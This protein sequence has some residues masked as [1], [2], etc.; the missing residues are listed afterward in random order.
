MKRCW[1]G[2]L[3]KYDWLHLHHEDF[4]G[5]YG[6][7]LR[8]RH[9]QWYQAQQQEAEGLAKKY[10]FAKVSQ[11]KLGVTKKIKEFVAGGGFMFAMCS[12]TD[13]YDIALAAEG[14]DIVDAIFDGDGVDPQ[15]QQK[16]DFSKTF[17]FQ[18]FT[19]SLSALRTGIFEH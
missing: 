8:H 13:T 4:T 14:V 11:M 18:D 1:T 7:S 6:K 19:I 15:A 16:L 3:L 12:A 10:G 9:Q 5:Q 17:A 2:K